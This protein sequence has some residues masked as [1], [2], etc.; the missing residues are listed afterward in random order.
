MSQ[1]EAG[2]KQR[3][4]SAR[5]RP[6]GGT[7]AVCRRG[8]M[9]LGPNLALAVLDVSEAGARLLLGA[10]L[11]KGQEVE[12][13]LAGPGIQRDVTRLGEVVWS[14]QTADGSHCVGIR[15]HKRIEYSSLQDL[16]HLNKV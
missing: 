8:A 4:G 16:S 10:A 12:I 11:P 14:V 9:G 15:F 3:R 13:S 2:V 5:R 7:K 6:K 1:R